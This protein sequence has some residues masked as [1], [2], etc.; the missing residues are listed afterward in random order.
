MTDRDFLVYVLNNLL[1]E[2]DTVLDGSQSKLLKSGYE[3]ITFDDTWGK[4][5]DCFEEIK[6]RSLKKAKKEKALLTKVINDK[7]QN[8]NLTNKQALAVFSKQSNRTCR[9][10]GKYGHKAAEC[11]H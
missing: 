4:L 5:R 10:C 8:T 7:L 3:E 9:S 2:Y 11:L 6:G 1:K